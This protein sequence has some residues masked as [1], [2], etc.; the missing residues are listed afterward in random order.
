MEDGKTLETHF[1][2]AAD[3]QRNLLLRHTGNEWE[4]VG[5]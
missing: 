3:N 4:A 5:S 2:I 1:R